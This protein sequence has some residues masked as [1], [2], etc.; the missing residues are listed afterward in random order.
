MAT[1]VRQEGTVA[2]PTLAGTLLDGAGAAIGVPAAI[3]VMRVMRRWQD[4]KDKRKEAVHKL[5]ESE[6]SE[7]ESLRKMVDGVVAFLVGRKGEAGLPDQ[8]GFLDRFDHYQR[9]VDEQFRALRGQV[10]SLRDEWKPNG[11]NSSYDRLKRLDDERKARD[12]NE[13]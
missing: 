10:K 7:V 4:R 9:S 6:Q 5:H 12:P 11:G 2:S 13:D 1:A 3:G 8:L